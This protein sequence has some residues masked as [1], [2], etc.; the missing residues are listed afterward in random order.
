MGAHGLA[1]GQSDAATLGLATFPTDLALVLAVVPLDF[2]GQQPIQKRRV[3]VGRV[4]AEW[5]GYRRQEIASQIFVA[6]DEPLRPPKDAE[7]LCVEVD[8]LA[9][10]MR[11]RRA[12]GKGSVGHNEL[13][14]RGTHRN[15]PVKPS[16]AANASANASGELYGLLMSHSN[17]STS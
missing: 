15:S 16:S 9:D 1:V 2:F 17:L 8:L 6:N 3:V 7:R 13:W 4:G 12:T 10:R 5:V 14:K 11:D